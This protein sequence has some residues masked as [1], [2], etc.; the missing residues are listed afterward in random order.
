MDLQM[1]QMNGLDATTAVRGE[2]PDARIIILTTYESDDERAMRAG[3]RAYVLKAQMERLGAI[4]SVY[5]TP[6]TNFPE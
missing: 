2:F 5:A 6:R 4:R 1:P 3:A